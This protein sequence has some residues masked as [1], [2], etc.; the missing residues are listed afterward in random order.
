MNYKILLILFSFFLISC[1]QI[2]NELNKNEIK[3][4]KKYSNSGFALIYDESLN[5]IKKLD[6]RS[7]MI[8]HKS[9]KRKSTVKITNPKNDKSLIAEVKS[10]NQKFSDFY[11]S[12]ISKRIA[13][14]LDLDFNE[15]L[16]EIALVSRNSTFIAKKSK[17]FEEEKKVAEKAPIDGI[18]IKDLN[19]TPKKKKKHTKLKFSYS[20]KLADF[21]YKSSAKMMISR[22]KN[23]T[24]IKNS[25]I[26]QLSKTKF[27]VLIG[28]FNDIK[29]LKETYEK[30][31][32]MNFENLEILNNV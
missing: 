4:E 8:Y 29:S 16:L 2:P 1:V 23:E 17:T 15:P 28:P 18:Q 25:R 10:N 6:D 30:L 19:S 12:V 26:Q 31:R 27:R 11:N 21:Y 3:L 7:L 24:N 22:I 9:L 13:E 5:K 32:P 20:I 14:D